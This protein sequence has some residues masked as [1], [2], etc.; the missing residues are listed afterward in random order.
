MQLQFG[1]YTVQYLFSDSS[2]AVIEHTLVVLYP[3]ED[4]CLHV[5]EFLPF[6]LYSGTSVTLVDLNILHVLQTA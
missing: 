6:S 4:C 1:L 5:L 2:L 3:L